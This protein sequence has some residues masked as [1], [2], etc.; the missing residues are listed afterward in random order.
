MQHSFL[1]FAKYI[2]HHLFCPSHQGEYLIWVK[3]LYFPPIRFCTAAFGYDDSREFPSIKY[4]QISHGCGKSSKNIKSTNPT[5]NKNI[6]MYGKA[7]LFP[8]S[9]HSRH[10]PLHGKLSLIQNHFISLHSKILPD[11]ILYVVK[12]FFCGNNQI[13]FLA[14]SIFCI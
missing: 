13:F 8:H 12:I 3:F 4:P 6:S 5:T 9:I 2:K 11:N 1:L 10:L 14:Y 7:P